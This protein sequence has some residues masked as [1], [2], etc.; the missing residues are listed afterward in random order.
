M[1][2]RSLSKLDRVRVFDAH[3][4]I[5]EFCGCRIHA[6]R[7][8]AW[9][10][11]HSI[12][13]EAGGKDEPSNMRPAHRTCHRKH[14]AEVDAPVIAKTKRLRQ[15]NLGIRKPSTLSHPRFKRKLDGTVVNRKTGEVI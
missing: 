9:D 10:V 15:K 5:C 8:E 14:T 6:E 3:D 1:T 4:G 7:G 12:P 2:R 11:S 13:L